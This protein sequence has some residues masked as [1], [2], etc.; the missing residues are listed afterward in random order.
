M[1]KTSKKQTPVSRK[2]INYWQRILYEM[3]REMEK[4]KNQKRGKK[5]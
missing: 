4:E 3:D 2:K 5:R 1:K